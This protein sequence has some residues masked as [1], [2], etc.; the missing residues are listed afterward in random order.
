LLGIIAAVGDMLAN[1]G[2]RRQHSGRDR[3]R[4]FLAGID[5]YCRQAVWEN[6]SALEDAVCFDHG[7]GDRIV[8][9]SADQPNQ[10]ED[11]RRVSV[12]SWM[13]QSFC[14]LFLFIYM[15]AAA[16]KLYPRPDRLANKD[17]VLVPGGRAGVWIV[18]ERAWGSCSLAFWFR[19]CQP[20]DSSDKLGFELKLVGG[21]VAAIALGLMLYWRGV[22]QKSAENPSA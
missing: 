5:R 10:R 22:R 7:A 14:T 4:T 2:R 21:T 9:D 13:P 15:F 11:T 1:A 8:R 19:W 3:P 20:G 18:S 16:I 6:S 17:A 12:F